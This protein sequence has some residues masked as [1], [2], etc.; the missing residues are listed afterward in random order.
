VCEGILYSHLGTDV[1]MYGYTV[2]YVLERTVCTVWMRAVII[3]PNSLKRQHAPGYCRQDPT[4]IPNGMTVVLLDVCL[5][6]FSR[7]CHQDPEANHHG[8]TS[9]VDCGA[10]V[11][12]HGR[13]P[14]LEMFSTMLWNVPNCGCPRWVCMCTVVHPRTEECRCRQSWHPRGGWHFSTTKNGKT[15]DRIQYHT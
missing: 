14:T 5:P 12:P 7:I 10:R 4:P 8:F 1:Y 3:T 11:G 9:A 6:W 13:P 2:Q 15:S